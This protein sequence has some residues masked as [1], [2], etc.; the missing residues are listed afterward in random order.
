MALDATAAGMDK[1]RL[2]RV[3]DHLRRRY[4]DPGK[5]AGCAVAVVRRG[6]LAHCSSLGLADRERQVPVRV[7]TLWRAYPMTKPVTG[8]ALM[9]LYERG[10]FQLDDPV[11]RFV[12]SWGGIQVAEGDPAH[13]TL[14]APRRQ[15]TVKDLLTHTPRLGYGSG[16]TD[17]DLVDVRVAARQRPGARFASLEQMA[18]H[19]A[20]GPLR[21]HPGSH[22]LYSLGTDMCARLV[23]VLS[24]VPFDQY[25]R[26]E[27]CEPLGMDDTDL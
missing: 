14:V 7:D 18:D 1:G 9:T 13:P 4:L 16:N 23:E 12:P 25:L 6:A 17:L 15:P 10:A 22:W 2:C 20:T 8:V 3:D 11:A 26:A 19:L 5:L 27:V 24:G 21:F